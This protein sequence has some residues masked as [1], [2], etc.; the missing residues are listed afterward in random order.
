M[1]PGLIANGVPP[2]VATAVSHRPPVSILF[3]TFLGYNPLRELPGNHLLATL[4]AHSANLLTG[5]EFF[6]DLIAGPFKAGLHQVFG[7]SIVICLIAAAASWSRGK[8]VET[9]AE[10]EHAPAESAGRAEGRIPGASAVVK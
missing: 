8:R 2:E 6:P 5:R 3:A 4:P 1:A 9:G 7:F 10:P